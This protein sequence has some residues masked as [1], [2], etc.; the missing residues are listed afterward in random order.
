MDIIEDI[1]LLD[2]IPTIIL[3][4]TDEAVRSW[5]APSRIWAFWGVLWFV[6]EQL[7]LFLLLRAS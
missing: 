5:G 7:A 6:L 4:V 1:D 3:G 2:L